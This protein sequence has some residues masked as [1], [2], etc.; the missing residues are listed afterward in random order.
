[1]RSAL[2]FT[3][4]L[5]FAIVPFSN[6]VAAS[7]LDENSG[8]TITASFDNSTEMTTLTIT[9]PVTNNA[10]LLDEL[11][12]TTFSIYR[13]FAG[14]WPVLAETIASEIQFCT[15]GT[16]NSECSGGIFQVEYYP[17]LLDS[18]T[19][20]EYILA[21][22][23]VYIQSNTLE[24]II[25]PNL[26][27]ENLTGMYS[28]DT[29]TLSWD[30]PESIPMNHSIMIYSHASPATRD[31]WNSMTKTILSSNVA[32]GSTSFEINHSS[33]QV[34]REIYYSVTLLYDMSEDTRFIGSNT[35]SEPVIEDNKA[36]VFDGELMATFDVD[37]AKTTLDWE[38]GIGG[39]DLSINIYR[40]EVETSL[41]D[42]DT[43]IATIDS[44]VSVFEVEVPQGTHRNSIYAITLQDSFGNE[45]MEL[46][47]MSPVSDYVLE[48]TISTSTVSSIVA[49]R[50]GDGTVVVS[51]EDNT[52]NSDAIA[53]VWRSTSGPI[54]SLDGLE[55][56]TPTNVSNGQ[57][58]HKPTNPQAQA[59]YAV[60]IEAAWGPSQQAWHDERLFPGVNSMSSP[61]RET[62]EVF[63]EVESN[64]TSQV[65]TSTGVRE[66]ISDSD[67]LFLG[68]MTE[69]DLIII[70]TS[71][72]VSNIACY[73]MSGEG[74]I[75]NSQ[76]D[77]SLSFSANQTAEKCYGLISEGGEEIVFTLTWNYI[78]PVADIQDDGDDDDDDDYDDKKGHNDESDKKDAGKIILGIIVL[79]LLIYLFAMMRSPTPEMLYFEEE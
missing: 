77:W 38:E 46:T 11:K 23:S 29:T 22:D 45:L 53:R 6:P 71:S 69:G 68:Q 9:M 27:V 13:V 73:D 61:I 59:W 79:V 39:D 55:E 16:S 37:T 44:R 52:Q 3:T 57:F 17:L 35:L 67:A 65:L 58:S 50:Y 42:P 20:Y 47:A 12:D 41:L 72:I 25:R 66:N 64:I 32:A 60:T 49:D 31:N 70:S 10:T 33:Y 1:M 18:H 40:Y 8:I 21:F 63:D 24:E 34:E 19:D 43:I 48:T 51:W 2:L 26:A 14:D 36:P 56:L 54:D 28:D 74:S 30:Y 62:E 76:S 78:E 5:L 4:I 7:G 15:Q 75:I